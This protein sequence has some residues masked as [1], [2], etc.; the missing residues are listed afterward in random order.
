MSSPKCSDNHYISTRGLWQEHENISHCHPCFP[1]CLSHLSIWQAGG[2]V[3]VLAKITGI[4]SIL[5]MQEAFTSY[6]VS[7]SHYIDSMHGAKWRL[8]HWQQADTE[9]WSMT[10]PLLESQI[11]AAAQPQ[12]LHLLTVLCGSI[13]TIALSCSSS[14]TWYWLQKTL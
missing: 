4:L 6:N 2:T 5:V 3:Y 13:A 10:K 8:M 11:F 14:C 7:M 1:F 9:I 12:I